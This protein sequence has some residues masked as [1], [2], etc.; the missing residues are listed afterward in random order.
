MRVVF[1]HPTLWDWAPHIWRLPTASPTASSF[2]NNLQSTQELLTNTD[3]N[4]F[5][6]NLQVLYTNCDQL[7]NKFDEL[8]TIVEH[9]KP[10]IIL[11]TEVIPKAQVLPIGLSR[12]TIP[13]YHLFSNFNPENSDL[14][15]SGCRGMVVY[16]AVHLQSMEVSFPGTFNE[17]LWIN[18]FLHG[19]DKLLIGNI[20]H[21]PSGDKLSSTN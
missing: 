10:D 12:L 11:L 3:D 19:N 21:S 2:L 6:N 18:I 8:L 5:L 7:L 9:S 14:G 16:V 15:K 4:E 13:Q 17:Q 20:Y 1:R